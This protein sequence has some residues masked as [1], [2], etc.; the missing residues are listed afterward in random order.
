MRWPMRSSRP[1]ADLGPPRPGVRTRRDQVEARRSV[2]AR[3]PPASPA[4]GVR[5][6]WPAPRGR[7]GYPDPAP[8][9]SPEPPGRRGS[10]ARP[11]GEPRRSSRRSG[12]KVSSSYLVAYPRAASPT[13]RQ[14]AGLAYRSD[15]AAASI[16]GAG[17]PWRGKAPSGV[18]DQRRIRQSEPTPAV[19]ATRRRR[20]RLRVSRRGDLSRCHRRRGR[21][22]CGGQSAGLEPG[23]RAALRLQ[24]GG[25]SGRGGSQPDHSRTDP[26]RAPQR[27]DSVSGDGR[28][29]RFSIA[30]SSSPHCTGTAPSSPSS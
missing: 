13:H 28:D 16:L 27:A 3:E 26:E 6:R 25:G 20:R 2:P 29:D 4:P 15:W 18:A 19:R 11:A 24:P 12:G 9:G 14:A 23:R 7:R 30:A 1:P 22:G 10:R 8:P 5:A 21:H 17:E